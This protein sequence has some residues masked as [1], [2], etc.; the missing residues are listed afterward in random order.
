[1]PNNELFIITGSSKGIGKALVDQLLED[2]GNQVIGI[3]R[4]P[5]SLVHPKF[6]GMALDLTNLQIVLGKLDEMMPTSDFGKI[7]LV[8]N[9]GMLGPIDHLGKLDPKKIEEVFMLNTIMPAVLMN[10]FIHKY[11]SKKDIDRLIVNISSGAAKKAIDGWACYSASKSALNM[12]SETAAVEAGL[13]QTGIRIFSVAP[14]VVDTSM[15]AEIRLADRRAF[16]S[17][18]KFVGL[19]ENDELSPP[20]FTAE[21]LLELIK[22]PGRFE[23]VQQDVREY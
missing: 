19:K 6:K 10:A 18:S 16:S 22:N 12:L 5:Q 8:N 14:G 4:S 1:M 2:P 21:K 3:A 9:A 20:K 7:V 15:Q 17:L 13:D 23:A 11:G